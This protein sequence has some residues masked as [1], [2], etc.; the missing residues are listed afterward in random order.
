MGALLLSH[1]CI[2]THTHKWVHMN[3][4]RTQS[5]ARADFRQF[6]SFPYACKN[7]L[8]SYCFTVLITT[9]LPSIMNLT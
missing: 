2:F 9:N 6:N 3:D 1:L 4:S 7:K 5:G 8:F